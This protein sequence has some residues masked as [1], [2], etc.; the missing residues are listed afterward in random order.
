VKIKFKDNS[1]IEFILSSPGN[2]SVVLGAQDAS[3]PLNLV[4]N[5]AE[6]TL[7]ELSKLVAGIGVPLPLIKK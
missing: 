3:N 5:S 1:Y 6:V 2:V 7:D 4:V